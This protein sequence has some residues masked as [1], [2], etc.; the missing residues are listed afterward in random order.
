LSYDFSVSLLYNFYF[1]MEELRKHIDQSFRAGYKPPD[2]SVEPIQNP[3]SKI[4]LEDDLH[5][6]N[7]V[8]TPYVFHASV[9]IVT[10]KN[11]DLFLNWFLSLRVYDLFIKLWKNLLP[12]NT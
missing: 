12:S 11:L 3:K 5:N 8:K 4:L 1:C 2:L 6:V 9:L 7:M 10:S